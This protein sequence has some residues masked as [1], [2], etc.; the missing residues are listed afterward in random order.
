MDSKQKATFRGEDVIFIDGGYLEVD[1]TFDWKK[2]FM[3]P[4]NGSGAVSGLSDELTLGKKLVIDN[5]SYSY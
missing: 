2:T 3:T 4:K 5:K 1:M